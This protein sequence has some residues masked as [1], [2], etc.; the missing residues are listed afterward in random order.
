MLGQERSPNLSVYNTLH[1]IQ[2]YNSSVDAWILTSLVTLLLYIVCL[3]FAFLPQSKHT[4][5]GKAETFTFGVTSMK[6]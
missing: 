1:F 6:M 5:L 4:Q 3:H 2:T